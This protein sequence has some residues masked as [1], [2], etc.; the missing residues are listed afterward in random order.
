MTST[1]DA[2]FRRILCATDFSSC[3]DVAFAWADALA[4]S[5][6]A[7][8]HVVHAWQIPV[9]IGPDAS[10]VPAA[11]AGDVEKDLDDALARVASQRVVGRHVIRAAADVGVVQTAEAI[12]ADLVVVGTHG[13]SGLPHVLL[14]SVAERVIRTARS[15]VV[16]IPEGFRGRI[17]ARP[18]VGRALVASDL[19]GD[20]ELATR[21]ALDV[22]RRLGAEID[23]LHVMEFPAYLER[24]P[25]I[26]DELERRALDDLR[27]LAHRDGAA[28]IETLV[29]SGRVARTIMTLANERDHDLILLPTH[30][31]TGAD[32]FFLGSVAERVARLARRPIM[33]L[34]ASAE[35]R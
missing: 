7:E 28:P 27:Q 20:T 34:R 13:R 18:L 9:L 24:H 15:P 17:T 5:L 32:R 29:R 10:Y 23:L 25:A 19:A 22:A 4:S 21:R 6:G 16:T 12:G 2:P 1:S 31:R 35:A 14:G 26:V 33:A 8:L 30:G 11:L 3:A